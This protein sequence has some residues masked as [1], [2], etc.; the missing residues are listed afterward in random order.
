[1]RGGWQHH[2]R[3]GAQAD[4]VEYPGGDLLAQGALG[5]GV[6]RAGGLHRHRE[7]LPPG[8]GVEADRGDVTRADALSTSGGALDV[9]GVDVAPAHDDDVLAAPADHDVALGEVTLV[10]GVQ[11]AVR[12]S[13]GQGPGGGQVFAGHR[14]AAQPD[15]ADL[16][17]T[18]RASVL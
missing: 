14:I 7:G 18:E 16:P 2:N 8:T 5:V 12:I 17:L 4:R 3:A 13:S 1:Q 9:D 6:S 11:P 15:P 10:A